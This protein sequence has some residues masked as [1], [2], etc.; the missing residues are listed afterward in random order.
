MQSAG[1][2][3]KNVIHIE[4]KTTQNNFQIMCM[5]TIKLIFFLWTKFTFE[6]MKE[7][8]YTENRDNEMWDCDV[9]ENK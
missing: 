8:P 1:C 6:G 3:S 7:M 5:W 9:G 4:I 2:M